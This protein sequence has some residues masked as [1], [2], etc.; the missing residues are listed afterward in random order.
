MSQ[1]FQQF[2]NALGLG[3]TYALLTLGLALVFSIVGMINFAHG[4]LMSICA[5]TLAFALNAGLSFPVSALLGVVASAI[6]ALLM[7]QIVFR[8][9]RGSAAS[10]MLLASLVLATLL[11]VVFQVAISARPKTIQIPSYLSGTAA[12]G[13]ITVAEVKLISLGAAIVLLIAM[14]V[15]LRVTRYGLAMRAASDDFAVLRLMGIRANRVIASAFLVSGLLA[16]I[17]SV[18]WVAPLGSVNPTMGLQPMFIAFIASVLG[19]LGSLR[20]AV[21]GAFLI[22]FA[23]VAMQ[24]YLPGGVSLYQEAIV[25]VVIIGVL[26]WRAHGLLGAAGRV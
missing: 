11:Q 3:G 15:F 18:L 13:R 22:A 9:L 16:G 26:T 19:G 21:L 17:A 5:Y 20:G 12:F 1:L 25:Y 24:A 8:P 10:T 2:I 23:Q 4:T 7:D 6:A 14:T